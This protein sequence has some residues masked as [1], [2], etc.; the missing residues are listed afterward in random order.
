VRPNLTIF[1]SLILCL[2]TTGACA[3]DVHLHQEKPALDAPSRAWL[4]RILDSWATVTRVNLRISPEPV[5]WLIAYDERH[6]WHLNPDESLLPARRRVSAT[7]VSF[8]GREYALH[9]ISDEGSVWLP[10]GPPIEVGDGK[11]PRVFSMP[12]G[13]GRRAFA[14]IALPSLLRRVAE[15][16]DLEDLEGFF[17]GVA[18]HELVHTRQLGD[19]MQRITRLRERYTVPAG[20][21]DNIIQET[22][23][24]N[25]EYVALYSRER[26]ALFQAASELDTNP[27]S[28]RR[29]VSEALALAEKRRAT[30]FTGDHAVYTEL[31]DI[32]LVL[33]GIGEWVHLQIA[34][35]NAPKDEPWPKTAMAVLKGNTDWVQE[36]GFALFVL[37]DQLVPNWQTRFLAADFPSPFAVLGETVDG[38]RSTVDGQSVFALSRFELLSSLPVGFGRFGVFGGSAGGSES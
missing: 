4:Q 12:Y 25:P 32:F 28:A 23:K 16:N 2:V 20:T 30:F 24:S 31:D 21:T 7:T 13:D 8:N 38:R 15:N 37:I 33:E 35:A 29:L 17:L 34:R 18:G 10:A 26:D 36:E 14:A 6:A 3:V 9:V 27:D 19:V 22:Y 1:L 11:P 5:P